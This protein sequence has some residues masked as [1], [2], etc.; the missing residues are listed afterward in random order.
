MKLG[1]KTMQVL[2]NFSAINNSIMFKKGKSLSTISPAKTVMAVANIE[3]DIN[4]EF[5]IYDL[6]RFLGTISLFDDPELIISDKY[7]D[8]REGGTSCTYMF[9]DPSL[10]VVPPKKTLELKNPEINFQLT[11]AILQKVLRAL[12]VAS[13]PEIVVA[14]KNGNIYLQ[15]A[16]TKGASNDM[17]SVEVGETNATFRMVFRAENIKLF[18]GDYSVSISSKGLSNFKGKDVEYWVAVESNSSYNN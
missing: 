7:M 1:Q 18:P 16:D 2:K 8:I 13:L 15:A 4:D 12:S 11:E 6:S 14:G 10:I 9:T 3:E 5:A 17:Y